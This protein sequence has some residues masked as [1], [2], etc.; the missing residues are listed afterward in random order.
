MG[1]IPVPVA[2][3]VPS[4]VF[5]QVCLLPCLFVH[6]PHFC[7]HHMNQEAIFLHVKYPAISRKCSQCSC[8]DASYSRLSL[9]CDQGCLALV[10]S[11][12]VLIWPHSSF[13][14]IG[15]VTTSS[16]FTMSS[17]LHLR[18]H[19]SPYE[20][21][22]SRGFTVLQSMFPSAADLRKYLHNSPGS[23]PSFLPFPQSSQ[24]HF[25]LLSPLHT[26]PP[27]HHTYPYKQNDL[28]SRHKQECEHLHL[29]GLAWFGLSLYLLS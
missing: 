25:T 3:F 23:S 24:Q 15:N 21:R 9:E 22:E 13:Q 12:Y 18:T 2:S 28:G 20:S 17:C 5:V 27:V 29:W 11:H 6:P 4:T 1:S 16:V 19:I 10:N 14:N 7:C 8:L 26:F